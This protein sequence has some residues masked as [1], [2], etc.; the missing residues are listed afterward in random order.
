MSE[1]AANALLKTLEEPR[2][3][4]L[5]ILLSTNLESLPATI[6]SRAQI[7]NFYPVQADKVYDYLLENH[8]VTR[9]QAKN[10]SCLSLGRPLRAVRFLEDDELYQKYLLLARTL[11]KLISFPLSE[12]WS[13]GKGLIDARASF[14][15]SVAEMRLI[16]EVWQGVFRDLLMLNAGHQDLLQFA[17]LNEEILPIYKNLAVSF[18]DN[19]GDLNAYLLEKSKLLKKHQDF[20]DANVSPKNLLDSLLINL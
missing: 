16:L 4:V 6:I 12:R 17:A 11:L 10:F 19:H 2:S 14:S 1:G 15:E 20:L 3:K 7:L 8:G 5:I 18:N 9:S 13:L